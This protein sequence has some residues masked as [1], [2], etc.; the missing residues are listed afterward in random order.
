MQ[1]IKSAGAVAFQ[2]Y[3]VQLLLDMSKKHPVP[4]HDFPRTPTV[5][6]HTVNTMVDTGCSN[7]IM[8]TARNVNSMSVRLS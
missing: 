6:G 4:E 5:L 8:S 7:S 2:N 1:L 3:V